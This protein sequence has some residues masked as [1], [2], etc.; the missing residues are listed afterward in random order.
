MRTM[1]AMSRT[2]VCAWI[3]WALVGHENQDRSSGSKP[4]IWKWH[5]TDKVYESSQDCLFDPHKPSGEDFGK[6][7]AV[8]DRRCYPSDFDPRGKD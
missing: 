5:F 6:N 8:T 7:T 3:L 2:L 1:H 4:F